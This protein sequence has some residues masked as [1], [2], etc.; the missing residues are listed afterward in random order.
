MKKKNHPRRINISRTN[1]KEADELFSFFFQ[2]T[3]NNYN[4][5]DDDDY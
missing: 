3:K 1:K 5:D 4:Y 2:Y